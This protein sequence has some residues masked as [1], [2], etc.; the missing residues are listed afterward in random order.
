MSG[1]A[2]L[3][4]A[5]DGHTLGTG[6]GGNESYVRGLLEGLEAGGF[7]GAVILYTRPGSVQDR[8]RGAAPAAAGAAGDVP[9]PEPAAA[10]PGS[11]LNV[12]ERP[13]RSGNP[14]LRLA[15]EVPAALRRDQPQLAHF[16]YVGP[17]RSPC[18][19]TLAVHDTSFLREPELLPRGV[20]LRLRAMTGWAVGRAAAVV[21]PS[22]WTAETLT[23]RY[24]EASDKT[25]VVPLAAS[26]SFV[27]AV[28]A[29]PSRT[30]PDGRVAGRRLLPPRFCLYAGRR[31]RRKNVDFLLRA[32]AAARAIDAAVPPLVL[33][34]PPADGDA[35]LRA[36][37]DDLGIGAELVWAGYMSTAEL[38]EAYRRA[39]C[40]AFPCRLEGFG[41]P[42]AEA[43]ACGCPVLAADEGGVPETLGGAGR[44]L[45]VDV[46]SSWAEAL[47][48]V[49]GD[50]QARRDL[51]R[52]GLERA[53]ALSWER[54]AAGW[55]DAA[56][57]AGC[58]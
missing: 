33:I 14:A 12:I 22:A 6:A 51:A 53:G 50:E 9:L 27:P 24:P 19:V 10:A 42:V 40:L 49:T 16:Q 58:L 5:L 11:R 39:D 34:G 32:Y 54:T 37:A 26:A 18:P 47:V 30:A 44:L 21:V 55:L 43:L 35:R 46:L 4:V 1:E 7:P 41:L 25:F 8:E 56:R 28:P 36:L 57:A 2:S 45:P 38:A 13:L 29:G 15:L 48:E 17:L 23:S 52:R 20:A 31:Q 3:R